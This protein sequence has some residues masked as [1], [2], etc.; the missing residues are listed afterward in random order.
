M[1]SL[2][3]DETQKAVKLFN[4]W[5]LMLS[6]AGRPLQAADAYR[7][8]MEIDRTN[9]TEDEVLPAILHNYS[10]VLRELGK[11]HEA[12]DYAERAHQKALLA[13]NQILANQSDLQRARIYRD[14]HE[15]DRRSAQS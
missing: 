7:H 3:Y 1:T 9:Q 11:L 8:A 13:G 6:D 4:D 2:G 14:E 5:G 10:A 12:E 15:Y